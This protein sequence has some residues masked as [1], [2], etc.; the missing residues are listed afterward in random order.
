MSVYPQGYTDN[1]TVR[2]SPAMKFLSFMSTPIGRVLRVVMGVTIFAIATTFN[3]GFSTFL[4]VFAF[5]PPLTGILGICPFNP[6]I[7]RP[8]RCNEACRIA[9]TPN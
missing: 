2:G 9:S 7:G 8:I 4:K 5:L 3:G 1:T 6:L